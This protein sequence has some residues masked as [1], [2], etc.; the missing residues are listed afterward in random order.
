MDRGNCMRGRPGFTVIEMLIVLIVGSMV[1]GVASRSF[2]QVANQRAVS[3]VRDEAIRVAH[4]ARSEALR[5]GRIIY[6]RVLPDS[7]LVRVETSTGQVLRELD[8]DDFNADMVGNRASVCYTGRGYALPGCTTVKSRQ[9]VG[10]TRGGD[11][12]AVEILPLGQVRKRL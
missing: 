9:P 8:S 4:E 5:S 12:T 1:L 3:N 11:S 10:F 7:N 6:M 2:V